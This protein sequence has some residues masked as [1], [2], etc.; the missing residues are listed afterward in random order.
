MRRAEAR[1][2]NRSAVQR[3]LAAS[4]WRSMRCATS[5]SKNAKRGAKK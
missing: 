3:A 4:C 5:G 2:E 1:M